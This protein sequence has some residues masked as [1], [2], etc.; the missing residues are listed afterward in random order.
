M[1]A[2]DEGADKIAKKCMLICN[3][4]VY[5]YQNQGFHQKYLLKVLIIRCFSYGTRSVQS[6]YNTT[7]YNRDY[8][9]TRLFYGSESFTKQFLKLK[10]S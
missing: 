9:I 3:L 7:C 5:I 6:L 2:N 10:E 8:A 4:V 1:A